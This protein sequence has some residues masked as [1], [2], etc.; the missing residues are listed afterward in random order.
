MKIGAVERQ[1]RLIDCAMVEMEL[2][3][4]FTRIALRRMQRGDYARSD[5]SLDLA[6]AELAVVKRAESE[7]TDTGVRR[8]I[9]DLAFEF[10][11]VLHCLDHYRVQSSVPESHSLR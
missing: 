7:I 8:R 6:R 3:L 9:H 10:D 1:Q 2:V 4:V 5:R 11:G